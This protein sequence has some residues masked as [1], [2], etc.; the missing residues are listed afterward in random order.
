LVVPIA[1]NVVLI[2][3]IFVA[4]ETCDI[5][6]EIVSKAIPGVKDDVINARV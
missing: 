2:L 4:S 6:T 5:I 1:V 3:K